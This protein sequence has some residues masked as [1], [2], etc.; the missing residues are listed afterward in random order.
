MFTSFIDISIKCSQCQSLD[1]IKFRGTKKKRSYWHFCHKSVQKLIHQ[2]G[3]NNTFNIRYYLTGIN[4][5]LEWSS[6]SFNGPMVPFVLLNLTF[7]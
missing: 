3:F 5:K 4:F 6:N 1:I 2:S 7:A